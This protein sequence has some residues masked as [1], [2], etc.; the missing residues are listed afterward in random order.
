MPIIGL[1]GLRGSGKTTLARELVKRYGFVELTFA[2]PLKLGVQKMFG[3]SDAQ[4]FGTYKE[5][6]AIDNFWGISPRQILQTIGTELGRDRFSAL[7][8]QVQGTIWVRTVERRI[9]ELTQS[10]IHNIVV[11]D[12]R[13]QDEYETIRKKGGIVWK[14][15]RPDCADCDLPHSTHESELFAGS[16]ANYDKVLYNYGSLPDLFAQLPPEF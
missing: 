9:N 13:F 12:I 11:S 8:P 16:F 3:L 14:L 1:V 15:V 4:V 2:E 5:K 7:F 10:G 6:D